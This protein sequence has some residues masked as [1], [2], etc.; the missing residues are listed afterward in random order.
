MTRW[1]QEFNQHPF[2]ATWST[3]L[4]EVT[5]LDVDDQT[6]VTTAQELARLKKVLVF[7]DGIITNA[8]PELTPTSIWNNCHPQANAC[9]QQVQAYASN[10]N[11]AHLVQ[12]NEHADN[13]LTYVRPYMVVPEQALEVYGAS[14]REFSEKMS[15]YADTFQVRA[16]EVNTKIATLHDEAIRHEQGIEGIEQRAKKFDAYLYD[17]VEGNEP[18][19]KYV[20]SM[21]SEI[22]EAHTKTEVLR[23]KLFDGPE[24]TS[25]SITNFES[26][27]FELLN[28]LKALL[29]AATEEHEELKKFYERIFGTPRAENQGQTEGGLKTELDTRLT[30]L[31]VYETEQNTRHSTLFTKIES[32]L[33]GATSAGLSSAYMKLKD[34]FNTPIFLYTLAFNVALLALLAGG[35]AMI[36]SS[37][38]FDPLKI[39]L[40]ATSNWEELLRT[41]L[42][43]APIVI[44][45]VWFA[46]FSAT[47]RNQYERLQQEYAHKEAL[48]SSYE[49]YKKQLQELKVDSDALQKELISMTID[50]ISYNPSKT[51][52]KDHTEKTPLHG[53]LEKLNLDETKKILEKLLEPSKKSH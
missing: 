34:R 19:E 18:A 52:D 26:N 37:I 40:I 28:S 43:R 6:V 15:E 17:G 49:S 7:V 35:L 8:D 48:A 38:S 25:A 11:Q 20:T 23:Q 42:T 51:L 9:L 1:F 44:P 3:L 46:I 27:T 36:S 50:T 53:L 32:L 31:D 24:S 13:L 4:Q 29:G 16:S 33:P 47:R 21:V 5:Q 10:R 30:Q 12:A 22:T 2:K 14:V 45:I 41:L 39:E